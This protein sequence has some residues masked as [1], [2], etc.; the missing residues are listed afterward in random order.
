MKTLYS[1]SLSALLSVGL[2]SSAFA[3][4]DLAKMEKK[5]KA[6]DLISIEEAERI[7]LQAKP[8]VI[9]DL[10][11]DDIDNDSGWK[12]EAEIADEQG[13]EWDVDIHAKTG[14]VL[15]VRRD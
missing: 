9:T 10:E 12:Y 15:N 3:Y 11:I 2:L 14:E 1:I 7:A 13:Y 5:I 6:F 8:G 4:E